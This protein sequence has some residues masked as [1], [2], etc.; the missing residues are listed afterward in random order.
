M[1]NTVRCRS[2]QFKLTHVGNPWSNE[3]D[4]NVEDSDCT[5]RMLLFFPILSTNSTIVPIP[6][7]GRSFRVTLLDIYGAQLN[8]AELSSS[9][10]WARSR[11]RRIGRRTIAARR[12][13]H[14]V[15]AALL[16]TEIQLG[17]TTKTLRMSRLWDLVNSSPP[18]RRTC[19]KFS[20]MKTTMGAPAYKHVSRKRFFPILGLNL[21]FT[22][23]KLFF[24][25]TFFLC[26]LPS[27]SFFSD[28]CQSWCN[29]IRS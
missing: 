25:I 4:A 2:D 24:S 29:L 8:W 5:V 22:I 16:Q 21:N 15:D 1:Q 27:F 3:A 12:R 28:F 10:D 23:S 6:Y 17:G 20:N 11:R 13:R 9:W 14:G 18:T 7:H 26:F 19:G